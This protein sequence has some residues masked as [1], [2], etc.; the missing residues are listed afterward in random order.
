MRREKRRQLVERDE[1]HAVIEVD[2][3][4]VRDDDQFLRLAGEL[5]GVFAELEGMGLIAGDEEQRAG[6]NRLDVVERIEVHEL[7]VAGQG[8]M[9]G[10]LAASCPAA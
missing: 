7:D 4:G 5:V 9:R 8:R 6:R 1:L 2:V 3:A 10:Q